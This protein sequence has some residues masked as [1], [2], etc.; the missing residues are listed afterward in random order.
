MADQTPAR[1]DTRYYQL[2]DYNLGLA[3]TFI[4]ID[5]IAVGLRVWARKKQK[6]DLE[7][8][9][10]LLFPALILTIGSAATMIDSIKRHAMGYEIARPATQS[11]ADLAASTEQ[12]HNTSKAEYAMDLMIVPA[13]CLIKLS[14]LAFYKRIFCV[15]KLATVRYIINTL[16]IF[17]ILWGLAYW[18]VHLFICGTNFNAFW[19]SFEDLRTKCIESL[20]ME[21]SFSITDFITDSIILIMPMPLLWQLQLQTSKKIAVSLVFLLGSGAVVSSAIRLAFCVKY[22]ND[23]FGAEDGDL[24]ITGMMSW[25]LLEAYFGILAACLPTV[26]FLFRGLSPESVINSIRSNQEA[27]VTSPLRRRRDPSP[28]G[29]FVLEDDDAGSLTELD[30][31]DVPVPTEYQQTNDDSV[32]VL[33]EPS[34]GF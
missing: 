9:H 25:L 7:M 27:A 31:A 17:V 30:S 20:K 3:I 13:L 26:R 8:D 34:T 4:F 10:W 2:A 1:V 15:Q 23:N 22:V 11:H 29:V 5:V 32:E 6:L 14:F 19:S 24:V 33:A 12:I 21:L 16:M 28:S 18:L